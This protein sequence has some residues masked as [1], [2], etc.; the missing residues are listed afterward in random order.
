MLILIV[1]AE[2]CAIVIL[3]LTLHNEKVTSQYWKDKY[4]D[5]RNANATTSDDRQTSSEL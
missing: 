4:Y 3:A 5:E 2:L 1:I